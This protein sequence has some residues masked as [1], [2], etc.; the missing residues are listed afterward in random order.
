MGEVEPELHGLRE[1]GGAVEDLP[2]GSAHLEEGIDGHDGVRRK[3]DSAGSM[4]RGR[5]Q[6]C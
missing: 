6:R 5:E 1:E 3:H 4:I 2:D